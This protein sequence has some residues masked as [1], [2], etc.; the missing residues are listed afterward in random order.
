MTKERIATRI[1]ET[2]HAQGYEAYFAGGC[3]RDTLRGAEP[4]DYDVATSAT[5]AEVQKLFPKTVPV[6]AQF[7]V[8]LVVEEGETFE[9]ATFRSEGGYQDGRHPTEVKF[10]GV[11]QDAERRDFTVN[12]LYF[13]LQK[14]EVIDYVG[15]QADLQAKQYQQIN[16]L[17]FAQV[18]ITTGFEW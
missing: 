4:K 5:P 9:V 2:L 16:Y 11:K 13:D 18:I 8:M 17:P 10:T 6:G 14:K 15:G 1:V 7:G 12:G 3:V